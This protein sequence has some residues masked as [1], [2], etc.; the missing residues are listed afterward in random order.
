MTDRNK[1]NIKFMWRVTAAHVFAYFIAGVFA[2]T[3]F[4]YEN[5]FSSNEILSSM[6]KPTTAPIIALGGT[7]LQVLRGIFIALVLLPLRKV[8]TEEK[9]GFLKLGLLILGL[10]VLSTFGPAFGS[11]E[12]FIYTK[13]SVMEQ[14]TGYPEAILWISLFIG[15]LWVLYKFEKKAINTIAITLLTLLVLM[16]VIGYLG[17][18]GIINMQN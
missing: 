3:L 2:M 6:M 9:Y 10:S 11:I 17:A 4:D 14:I 12:G 1:E 5:W 15:I 18:S 16:G 8:F 13:M 7:S